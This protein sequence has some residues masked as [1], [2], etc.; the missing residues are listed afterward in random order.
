MTNEILTLIGVIVLIWVITFDHKE[1]RM[2]LTKRGYRRFG[3]RGNS[4][5]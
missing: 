5:D 2:Y 3:S 1:E 4:R